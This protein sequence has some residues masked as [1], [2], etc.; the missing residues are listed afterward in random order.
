MRDYPSIFHL[1]VCRAKKEAESLL[2]LLDKMHEA[3]QRD[4]NGTYAG[5]DAVDSTSLEAME[6]MSKSVASECEAA[7]HALQW[8]KRTQS[9]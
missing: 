1:R 5:I 3:C 2:S 4:E 6:M 9:R 7:T 8:H